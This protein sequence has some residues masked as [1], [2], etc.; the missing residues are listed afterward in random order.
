MK[1]W[2]NVVSKNH[3]QGGVEGGFTQANH[4]KPWAL[5]KMKKGDWI[6]FYSP[7][8]AFENGESLQAFTAL[9]QI[10]DEQPYQTIV[11]ETFEPWRRN[12][13]FENVK[14]ASIRP[15]IEPLEFIQNK[16]Q[17]GYRFRLGVIEINEHDY[18]L[19]RNAMIDERN[20]A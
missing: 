20:A 14:E 6:I 19:I 1:Y 17:W 15:L 11:N 7:K 8:T 18:D 16:Q 5:K 9:G 2:I 12:V 13:R 10:I 3:V 4:G